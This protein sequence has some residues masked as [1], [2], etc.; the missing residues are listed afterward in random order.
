MRRL[1][2]ACDISLRKNPM[3]IP[4]PRRGSG[5]RTLVVKRL[6]IVKDMT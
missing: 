2:R 4:S 6:K 3:K 5:G 1:P